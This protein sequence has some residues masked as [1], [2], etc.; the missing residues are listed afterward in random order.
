MTRIFLML[1][2]PLT[3][4]LASCSKGYKPIDYGSDGCVHC[5]MTIVDAR[6]GAEL[7]TDKGKVYKFD[8]ILCLKQYVTANS[9][10]EGKIQVFVEKYTEQQNDVT[11]ARQAIYIQH[12]YF[13]SPMNGNY[14]AFVNTDE[15]QPYADSLQADIIGW[16]KI[17]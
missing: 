8:D 6:Y 3:I 15:A 13:A 5:K 11:D 1:F 12:E 14:A 10:D 17:Q 4:L 2:I 7:V 16:N 9:V